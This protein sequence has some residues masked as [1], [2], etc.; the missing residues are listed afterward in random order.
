MRTNQRYGWIPDLP[1]HR[2]LRYS[3]T[4]D[5]VLNLPTKVDL[6]P[7]CPPVYNQ[8][9]LGSCTGNAI[10][11]ALEFER[12][13]QKL[14]NTIPSRLFIYYNE[15]VM[16]GT[17][18]SD[19]GAM[20]RDGIKSVATLGACSEDLWPYDIAQFTVRPSGAAYQVALLDRVLKYQRVAQ[21]PDN[22]GLRASLSA[23]FPVVFGFS[24]YSRFESAAVAQSGMV[25]MPGSTERL[26]G[27]HAV[28]AVG[29]DDKLRLVTVRNSWGDTW[30]DKGYCYMP[31]GYFSSP[32]LSSDFWNIE[33]VAAS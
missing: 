23:G 2:D 20:I 4:V 16:E 28:V 13:R 15:R 11:G 24:V 9:N 27:G 30:G 21:M 22:G 26:L 19:S 33:L 3:V 29:Y 6:R 1:D 31:Y 32:D 25:P 5:A 8:G 7:M 12:L 14:P 10:A 17:V 18:N